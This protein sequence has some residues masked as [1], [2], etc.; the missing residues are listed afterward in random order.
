MVVDEHIVT[1][2]RSAWGA[3][4]VNCL[5]SVTDTWTATRTGPRSVWTVTWG[6]YGGN[7]RVLLRHTGV[8]VRVSRIACFMCGC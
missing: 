6:R 8:M 7:T 3:W 4:T 2:P 5:V 1:K